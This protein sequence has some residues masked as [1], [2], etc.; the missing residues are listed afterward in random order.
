MELCENNRFYD[1]CKFW[2]ENK[3]LTTTDLSEIY[4]L[5]KNAIKESLIRG[6]K[7]WDWCNY[8]VELGRNLG[9]IKSGLS[10][11]IT[12]SKPIDIYKDDKYINSYQ[13]ASYLSKI[14]EEEL[15]IKLLSAKISAVANGD[16]I[17]HKGFT[18]KY[19]DKPIEY[20]LNK[21]ECDSDES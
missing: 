7:I 18:F 16:R 13:S 19:S 8:T 9:K 21:E 5:S 2:S 12:K 1:L 14:S 17:T 6:S 3:T 20:F 15:G 10:K 4:G 11:T